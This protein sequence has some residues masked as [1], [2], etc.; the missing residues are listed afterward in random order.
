M[1]LWWK[2]SLTA[3]LLIDNHNLAQLNRLNYFT[4]TI[5]MQGNIDVFLLSKHLIVQKANNI[6]K[7]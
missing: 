1:W 3:C 7:G 2:K 6:H 4:E 5:D